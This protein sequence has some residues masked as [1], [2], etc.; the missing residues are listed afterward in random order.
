[1]RFVNTSKEIPVAERDVVADVVAGEFGLT[2]RQR[3]LV[4][5]LF[6]YLPKRKLNMTEIS[7]RMGITRQRLY[8]LLHT[9][10]EKGAV[11]TSKWKVYSPVK[12]TEA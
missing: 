2:P 12:E 9:L 11:K 7:S 3:D 6:D 4:R 8:D 10:M 5:V 1:M